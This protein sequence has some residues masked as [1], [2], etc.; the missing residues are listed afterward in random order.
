VGG[1]KYDQLWD[2]ISIGCNMR[3]RFRINDA[4]QSPSGCSL[5]LIMNRIKEAYEIGDGSSVNVEYNLLVV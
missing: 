4:L 3:S 2:A 1:Q 5:D